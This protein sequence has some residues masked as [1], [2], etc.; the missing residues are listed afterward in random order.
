MKLTKLTVKAFRG[1]ESEFTL[2]LASTKYPNGLNL[3]VFGE[4]GAAKS[5]LARALELF[6]D[7]RPNRDLASHQNLFSAATPSIELAF[8]GTLAGATHKETHKWTGTTPRPTKDWLKAT[9]ARSAFLDHRKLLLL[10]DRTRGLGESF[11]LAAVEHFFAHLPV[12]ATGNTVGA[13]WE[14]ILKE[15]RAYRAA[16]DARKQGGGGGGVKDPVA[17]R[18]EVEDKVNALNLAL[19]DYLV[20]PA[21][22]TPPLVAETERLLGVLEG[23]LRQLKLTLT[24][25]HLTF[26]HTDG[27]L[28]GGRINPRVTFCA[29]DLTITQ[30][31]GTE[32][33]HHHVLNE[34]RLTALALALFFA[35]AKLQN[36]VAY[37]PTAGEPEKPARLLVMDDVL[38]GLDYD[39]RLSVLDIIREE[40]VKAGYQI[41]LLTHNRVW[42]DL[43][44]L[45]VEDDKTWM[46]AELYT[47]RGR[48]TDKSDMPVR[49]KTTGELIKRAAHFL[50]KHE[51]PAAANYA[52]TAVETALKSICDKRRLRIPFRLDPERHDTNVF[53]DAVKDEKRKKKGTTLLVPKALQTT[54]KSLRKTVLNPLTHGNS[55]TVGRAE[56]ERAIKA[57]KQ[58]V[59]I[60]ERCKVK[61]EATP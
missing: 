41:V 52:R 50:G 55:T 33:T 60:A 2:P 11:F 37:I 49:K 4:N 12:S 48:G 3:L 43:C 54:L 20:A 6:F 34:A 9:S 28:S 53:L 5:S 42:F 35:A 15:Q 21:G 44:R 38:V 23:K 27:S 57:A 7:T 56:I 59:K 24:F 46:L 61:E 32:A 39:H 25:D 58:L 22:Q 19:D 13:L 40:F 10:S 30:G 16:L 47:K 17:H 8:A 51:W 26:N 36:A 1:I 18:K 14:E 29:K 31:T 45:E